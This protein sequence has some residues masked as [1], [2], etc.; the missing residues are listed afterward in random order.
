[1]CLLIYH[2][3]RGSGIKWTNL[4][5]VALLKTIKDLNINI[6]VDAVNEVLHR[7][8]DNRLTSLLTSNI[9]II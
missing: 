6:P 5:P 9:S 1:M 3:F 2:L 7:V 8:S 4:N